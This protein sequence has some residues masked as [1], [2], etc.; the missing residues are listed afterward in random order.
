MYYKCL[1]GFY[2]EIHPI[3][4]EL[5]YWQSLGDMENL[6]LDNYQQNEV[7]LMAAKRNLVPQSPFFTCNSHCGSL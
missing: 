5:K 7:S 4:M 6:T 1:V 3:K 2:K